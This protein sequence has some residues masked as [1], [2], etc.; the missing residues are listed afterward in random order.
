MRGGE[1]A[2]DGEVWEGR[3]EARLV[4][5]LTRP[6]DTECSAAHPPL[7]WRLSTVDATVEPFMNE[8][9]S[10]ARKSMTCAISSGV[11]ALPSGTLAVR[12]T[13]S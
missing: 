12:R 2:S 8:L 3:G 7:R 1:A 5:L 6:R 13:E 9:L 4:P 10:P 11:A